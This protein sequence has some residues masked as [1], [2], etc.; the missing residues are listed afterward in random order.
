MTR[1]RPHADRAGSAS[2]TMVLALL[3]GAALVAATAFTP[4]AMA[5]PMPGSATGATTITLGGQGVQ[6]A[7]V[8][9][10]RHARGHRR[11]RRDRD[12]VPKGIK[13]IFPI[14]G[15][16]TQPGNDAALRIDHSGSLTL[17]NDCYAITLGGAAD[18]QLRA[19]GPGDRASTSPRSPSRRTTPVARSS[20]TLDL[21]G[22][23]VTVTGNKTRIAQMSLLTSAEGAR[24]AQRARRRTPR[25]GRSRL[26]RRSARPRRAWSSADDRAGGL[27]A[28]PPSRSGRGRSGVAGGAGQGASVADAADARAG[29]ARPAGAGPGWQRRDVAQRAPAPVVGDGA[30][31]GPA[32][33]CRCP[34]SSSGSWATPG[35]HRR[36]WRTGSPP[37][38]T[39]S[40][41]ATRCS[42]T[43]A[44]PRV[45]RT[46]RP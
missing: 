12:A 8:R 30:Q 34:T 35:R 19:A 13:L 15:M 20:L 43:S 44:G 46:S 2:R 16:V 41:S 31:P 22:A 33:G 39:T 42:S 6:H 36:W 38:R 3:A 4:R 40:W 1:S 7:P 18:H 28:G 21:T 9:R 10:L 5:S 27:W 45:A 26:G 17:E 29:L 37:G 32:E 24:G 23:N 11:E 14:S 25:P